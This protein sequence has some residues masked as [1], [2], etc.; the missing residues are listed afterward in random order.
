MRYIRG[1]LGATT[2]DPK[3]LTHAERIRYEG[4]VVTSLMGLVP[5]PGEPQGKVPGAED[6]GKKQERDVCARDH[7]CIA[8]RRRDRKQSPVEPVGRGEIDPALH[9]D[10]ESAGAKSLRGVDM[11]VPSVIATNSNPISVA[12]ELPATMKKLS[13]P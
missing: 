8:K 6:A 10:Q 1:V 11:T 3:R 12:A 13:Q 2:I 9:Q 7:A 4:L 5:V